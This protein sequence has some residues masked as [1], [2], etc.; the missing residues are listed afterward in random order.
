MSLLNST[1][2]ADRRI[3]F[4]RDSQFDQGKVDLTSLHGSYYLP[5]PGLKDCLIQDCVNQRTAKHDWVRCA[6]GL[7]KLELHGDA[8]SGMTIQNRFQ[9]NNKIAVLLHLVVVASQ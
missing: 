8:A 5:K 3:P 4:E 2:K 7:F 6:A 9:G 1:F